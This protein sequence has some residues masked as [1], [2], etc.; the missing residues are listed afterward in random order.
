MKPRRHAR[1]KSPGRQFPKR[2]YSAAEFTQ[3]FVQRYVKSR[4]ETIHLPVQGDY[5]W[6]GAAGYLAVLAY[7]EI[8]KEEPKRDEFVEAAKASLFKKYR[9]MAP[10]AEEFVRRRKEIGSDYSGF[11]NEHMLGILN[12]AGRRI[13]NLRLR[14]A[15][16]CNYKALFNRSTWQASKAMSKIIREEKGTPH[17]GWYPVH[18]KYRII[19]DSMPVLHLALALHDFAVERQAVGPLSPLGMIKLLRSPDD[20][21]EDA[22]DRAEVYRCGFLSTIYPQFK[23]E[24]AICLLPLRE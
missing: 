21:L 4:V 6:M 13:W 23:P 2:I 11:K 15:V 16:I 18:V 1:A 8:K 5:K 24:D 3:P 9:D 10:N 19:R 7:P 14:A 12:R 17:S 20:W 22:L